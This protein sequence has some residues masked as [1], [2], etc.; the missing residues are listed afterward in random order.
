MKEK[1]TGKTRGNSCA[2]ENEES[3]RYSNFDKIESYDD[4]NV[5]D[6]TS[7][8]SISSDVD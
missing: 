8:S 1:K 4:I 6:K 2:H 3:I 5:N 7:D